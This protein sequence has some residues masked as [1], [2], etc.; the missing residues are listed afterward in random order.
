MFVNS[1]KIG[2]V[3]QYRLVLI[4]LKILNLSLMLKGLFRFTHLYFHASWLE[5]DVSVCLLHF[6]DRDIWGTLTGILLI[7]Y[8]SWMYWL[9]QRSQIKF[10][11]T[12]CTSYSHLTSLWW[13]ETQPETTVMLNITQWLKTVI[14]ARQNE[15]KPLPEDLRVRSFI[16]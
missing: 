8:N 10:A 6:C 16:W 12:S 2:L 3:K 7:W 9:D 13:N 15:M 11:V 4:S 1:L 14:E 5:T